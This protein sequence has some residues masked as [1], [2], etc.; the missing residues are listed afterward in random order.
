MDTEHWFAPMAGSVGT[1]GGFQPNSYLY[2]STSE[3]TPFP[4][5]IYNNNILYK[6][7]QIAKGSPQ[8][9]DIP[10]SFMMT[11]LNQQM[12]TPVPMGMNVKG[13]KRFFAN[14]RFSVP[15]HAEI[16]TS[17]GLAGV[18]KNFFAV[19]APNTTSKSYVNSTIGIVATQ[20]NT[21]VTVSGYDPGI[22]F[23]DG[24]SSPS[25]TFL[26]NK[27]QSYIID[28]I[29]SDNPANLTGLIGAKIEA[30]QPIAITNGNFNG[31]Y[32]YEN[33]NNN[34]IEMDQSVPVE[35]LGNEFIMVKGNGPADNNMESAIIVA[36]EDDTHII[37]NGVD[38]GVV[39]NAGK[40]H[41]L[42]ANN[43][44]NQ[45]NE[46]YNMSISTSKNAYVY[47][48]LAGV[49]SSGNPYAT[50]GFN[51]I[52][53]LSCFLPNKIDEISAINEIGSVNYNAKLN[54]ITEKG[55]TVLVNGATLSA[56]QGP[57]PVM[58]NSSW[59]TYNVLNISGNVTVNS[60]RSVTA[61]IAAGD[62][63]VGYGGY[64][65]GFSSV[66]VISKTGDCY[67]GVLFQV[68][69]SYDHY[70]WFLNGVSIPGET[71]YF[72]N[73]D[74]YGEG[75]YT[76]IIT[77]TN[78]DTKLT[79]PYHFTV[80]PPISTTT[81][82][83]GSCKNVVISPHFTASTQII[84]PSKTKIIAKPVYGT[85]VVDATTGIITYT[86]NSNLTTDVSDVFVYYIEG[87][88][89]PEDV[90]YFKVIINI[91]VLV[92]M[93]DTLRICPNTD[94]SG[95]YN[96]TL[97]NI[98]TDPSNTIKYFEDAGLLV[99][100]PNFTNY[101][102]LPKTVYAEVS[103][104]YGC[105]KVGKITLETSNVPILNLP[106][107][108]SNFCDENF[109]GSVPITFSTISPQII[110]NYNST[111]IVK[112]YLNQADQQVGNTNFLPDNWS[113]TA[114]TIVYV[115]V[116]NSAGCSVVF[117]QINF[118]IGTQIP[119]I[120]NTITDSVC[121]NTLA[122]NISV[123][124]ND[125]ISR[126]TA[127]LSI[128]ATY[129]NTENEAKLKQNP[130]P[131]TQILTATKTF[132]IR[133]ESPTECPNI[134]NFTLIFKAPRE[135]TILQEET[136]CPS[137]TTFLDAGFGF[138][139]YLWSTGE[140]SQTIEVGVGIYYVDLGFNGCI[141]RQ[142]VE[143]KAAELPKITNI[144]VVGNTATVFVMGGNP[145]YQYSL[146]NIIF[147][148]S[149]V[150]TDLP[151]GLHTVFVR[152]SQN[153][154]TIFKQFL[155]INLINVITPNG[156]GMND[157]LDY[158]DLNI[159]KAVQLEIYDRYGNQVYKSENKSYIWNGKING[160]VLPT[161]NY[162]YILNWTEPDTNLPVS[163]KAWILL[164]NRN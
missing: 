65:A 87:N 155:I 64:F 77:K 11:V 130:I 133:L 95:T 23:A 94:G 36:T 4:V 100:I 156:D 62:G 31:I 13:T 137:F 113:F 96:L 157:V 60:T 1:N 25:K 124:L 114:N 72:L 160:R 112:Y 103:S 109:S 117:G 128:T 27:G 116:E 149:N 42:G 3:T 59:E 26:L 126:F 28:A 14:Y 74:L 45:G 106:N 141:Y 57:F 88:G 39:L 33:S 132:Y 30:T 20:D 152:D 123:N 81:F 48:L 91:K 105:S 93:D 68:D 53:G 115:R 159:K 143:V 150:F 24:S 151:R 140:T 16:I 9:V 161:G 139:S 146:D 108:N 79:T 120:T 41:V 67:T 99:P 131:S 129:Y 19:M 12:F 69:D 5:E 29:S 6:T 54:I 2:L 107:F 63:A 66:P 119:L 153:C 55:A 34:D 18:G 21:S 49:G 47:Q 75:D 97:A 80:C 35:R 71:T 102:S 86:P 40:Y 110:S 61:G 56:N 73:P 121:D 38:S 22:V 144:E 127:D 163:Y 104:T 32:T 7:V 89:T 84:V 58:G 148:N 158:S 44:K 85:A 52:P 70:Q 8:V 135:S 125:Y 10:F 111:F 98:S 101:N 162:W 43:Y 136:I 76:C 51:F 46:H 138:D 50:G 145:P 154:E 15:N 37:V 164:K 92:V 134:A 142:T 122:G 82:T 17:K 147:Q 118:S 78:C 83:L 90:E